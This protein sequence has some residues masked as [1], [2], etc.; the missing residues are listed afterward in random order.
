VPPTILIVDDDENI[1]ALTQ[2]MLTR[3]GYHAIGKTDPFEAVEVASQI[4]PDLIIVDLMM[5][6]MDGFEVALRC[7]QNPKL[8]DIPI[9]MISAKADVWHASGSKANLISQFLSKPLGVHQLIHSISTYL[10]EP[11][12]S[13]GAGFTISKNAGSAPDL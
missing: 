8:A 6:G 4:C 11:E 1:V 3:H 13:A 7:R 9:L 10:G 5:P 12:Q 2:L